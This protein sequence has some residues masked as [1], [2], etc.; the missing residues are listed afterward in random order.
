MVVWGWGKRANLIKPYRVNEFG[1]LCEEDSHQCDKFLVQNMGRI[2]VNGP[3]NKLKVT[4]FVVY[5]E[6]LEWVGKICEESIV[7]GRGSCNKVRFWHNKWC[8]MFIHFMHIIIWMV[9]EHRLR[10]ET[11]I[12]KNQFDFMLGRSTMEAI[13]FLRHLTEKNK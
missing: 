7:W 5:G 3:L 12:S 2:R 13:F 6:V 4:M 11:T 10:H 8:S 1:V 9:I